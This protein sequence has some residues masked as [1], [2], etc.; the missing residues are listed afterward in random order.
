VPLNHHCLLDV[1][2]V[3]DFDQFVLATESYTTN[4]TGC[5]PLSKGCETYRSSLYADVAAIF[6]SPK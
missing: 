4:G 1:I 3:V 5:A 6:I 2:F